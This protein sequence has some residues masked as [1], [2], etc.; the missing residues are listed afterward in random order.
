MFCESE[1]WGERRE[2]VKVREVRCLEEEIFP[3]YS[4]NDAIYKQQKQIYKG[5]SRLN[6]PPALLGLDV[7][8][9]GNVWTQTSAPTP[10]REL[11]SGVPL[12]SATPDPHLIC[13]ST[14]VDA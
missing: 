11:C 8:L 6:G 1:A 14:S 4:V 10:F 3:V 12:L 5:S 7:Y 9:L 2:S 13:A